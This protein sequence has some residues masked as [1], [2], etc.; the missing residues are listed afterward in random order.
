VTSVSTEPAAGDGTE[1][2]TLAPVGAPRRLLSSTVAIEVSHVSKRFKKH[3]ERAK[4]LKER[5]LTFRTNVV[6]DFLALNE[7]DFDVKVGETLGILGH[8]GSGKSTLL[9][10]I[11]GTIRPG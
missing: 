6:D 1:P 5:V 3:S 7:V 2:A 9:K 10:C 8:N 4:T 11:A